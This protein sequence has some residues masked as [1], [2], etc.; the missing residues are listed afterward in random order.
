MPDEPSASEE[1]EIIRKSQ[2]M[3][4]EEFIGD[5]VELKY[6]VWKR[7]PGSGEET[8]YVPAGSIGTVTGWDGEQFEIAFSV[9]M[10]VKTVGLPVLLFAEAIRP[11]D[12][13]RRLT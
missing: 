3:A 12:M 13:D 7:D 9:G 8:I 2:P 4:P 11:C 1:G 10:S 5:R 6:H